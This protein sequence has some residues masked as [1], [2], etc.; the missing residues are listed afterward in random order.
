MAGILLKVINFSMVKIQPYSQPNTA[1]EKVKKNK[2]KTETPKQDGTQ[3][4]KEQKIQGSNRLKDT[5]SS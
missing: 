3:D 2:K 1:S 4:E 5:E